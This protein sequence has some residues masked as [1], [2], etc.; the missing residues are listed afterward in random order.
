MKLDAAEGFHR[1][2]AVELFD[3]GRPELRIDGDKGKQSIGIK[4]GL[5]GKRIVVSAAVFVKAHEREDAGLFDAGA[6]EAGDVGRLIH[7]RG[8]EPALVKVGVE[9]DKSHRPNTLFALS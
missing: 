5:R 8:V 6:I 7:E 9:V 4:R 2:A 1:Q 3:R